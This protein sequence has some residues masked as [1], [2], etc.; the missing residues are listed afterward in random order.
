MTKHEP[1]TPKQH[2]VMQLFELLFWKQGVHVDTNM[3]AFR[4]VFVF[5]DASACMLHACT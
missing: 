3:A 2:P 5:E 1:L 4:V